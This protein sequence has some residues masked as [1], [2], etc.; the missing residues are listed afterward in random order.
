MPRRKKENNRLSYEE[1]RDQHDKLLR[2]LLEAD[3]D[4]ERN[5]L[6]SLLKEVR[7]AIKMFFP[8]AIAN[9]DVKLVRV[10]IQDRTTTPKAEDEDEFLEWIAKH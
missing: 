1:L 7:G 9:E 2:K 6:Q 8:T 5:Q 3:S 4:D 10:V